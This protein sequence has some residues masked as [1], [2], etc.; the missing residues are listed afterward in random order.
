MPPTYSLV[1]SA[2][3]PGD[4]IYV[5]DDNGVRYEPVTV[6][7]VRRKSL[8]TA[9]G[10]IPFEDHGWLWWCNEPKKEG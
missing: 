6:L 5:L 9:A 7:S 4:T 3:Q 8:M 1:K 10:E 2:I